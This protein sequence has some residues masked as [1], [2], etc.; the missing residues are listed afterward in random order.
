MY[1]SLEEL[2]L[3]ESL[4]TVGYVVIIISD[5]FGGWGVMRSYDFACLTK[6][7]GRRNLLVEMHSINDGGGG[8]K[9]SW[10]KL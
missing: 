3:A 4:A 9:G 8:E 7:R 6:P 5:S 1:V 10:R 2:W